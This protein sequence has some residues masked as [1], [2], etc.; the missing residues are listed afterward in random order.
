MIIEH[1]RNQLSSNGNNGTL[2]GAFEVRNRI[3][4]KIFYLN[5]Y[6]FW[7]SVVK[8]FLVFWIRCSNKLTRSING[9]IERNM[10][11]MKGKK[12]MIHILSQNL[13]GKLSLINKTLAIEEL[14][15]TQK[16]HI[17]C[18]QEP[19]TSELETIQIPNYNLIAGTL[20]KEKDIRVNA[21]VHQSLQVQVLK[22]Q[23]EIPSLLLQLGSSTK[24]LIYYREWR[25]NGV[26]GTEDWDKQEKRFKTFLDKFSKLRGRVYAVGDM[27]LSYWKHDTPYLR[28][29]VPMKDMLMDK[30][31][32]KGYAQLISQDTHW[33]HNGNSSCLDHLYSRHCQYLF[34]DSIRV[35]RQL[36]Y[37]HGYIS[38]KLSLESPAFTQD[39][40][41]TRNIKKLDP[42]E[43]DREWNKL[44]FDDFWNEPDVDELV[45]LFAH[46]VRLVL[47][48]LA[49][50]RKFVVKSNNAPYLTKELL[51]DIKKREELLKTAIKTKDP[52]DYKTFKQFRNNLRHREESS[53]KK[54]LREKL[55]N[56]DPKV[57]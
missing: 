47:D 19:R 29:Q 8:V 5:L 24:L 49:P 9:N 4:S 48:K 44:Q 41:E 37:D 21:Y 45:E 16:P 35:S 38:F 12:K 32:S 36:G 53:K 6:R 39:V 13:P 10:N 55:S 50:K 30:I 23:T 20:N 2:P 34:H 11:G 14:F 46:K 27:N 33:H 17:L 18:L 40:I 22:F 26:D 25:K 43:F 1:K 56:K 52:E 57:S 15:R 28:K 54:F 51:E 3:K 7:I 31:I 42:E